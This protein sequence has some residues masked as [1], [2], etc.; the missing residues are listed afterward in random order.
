ML[1]QV[2]SVKWEATKF[3]SDFGQPP[4]QIKNESFSI[5]ANYLKVPLVRS[6]FRA[7]A[8]SSLA[9]W[10]AVRNELDHC[11]PDNLGQLHILR[12]LSWLCWTDAHF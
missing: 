2:E 4:D 5:Q 10:L 6:E 12:T 8:N 11:H 9:F 1:L 3:F 7:E